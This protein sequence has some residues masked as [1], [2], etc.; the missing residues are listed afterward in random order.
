MRNSSK[1]ALALATAGVIAAGASAYT[2]TS[3]IDQA[4]VHVG[5]VA[6]SVSGATITNVVHS[7]TPATDTTTAISAKAEELLSTTAGAV[8][9]S[10]NGGALE[11]CTVTQT[12]V[13]TDGI[14]D[15]ATDFSDIAC[16]IAD[17]AGVTSV[18]FVVNG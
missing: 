5:S 13:N 14:D 4:A 2:A 12:D 8:Q 16:N 18:R 10:I 7:Y 11:P 17:T 6:Q 3:T 1:L 9:V 15:G